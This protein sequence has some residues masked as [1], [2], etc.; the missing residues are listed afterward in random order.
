[1][2]F[3]PSDFEE[4][5]EIMQKLDNT[6][7]SI[8]FNSLFNTIWLQGDSGLESEIYLKIY[9]DKLVIARMGF[10]NRHKGIGTEM[11]RLLKDYAKKNNLKSV[12][13]ESTLTK[14]MN[15]FCRK[16]GFKPV[17][18]QCHEYNG[19]IFGNYELTL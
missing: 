3:N 18:H 8:V 7:V 2:K 15:N 4:I 1:M 14:E 16:Y 13:V 12:M 9:V 6:K 11:L 10:N 5:K 19:D 17:E